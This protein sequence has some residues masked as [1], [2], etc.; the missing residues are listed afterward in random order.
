MDTI[1][2][3]TKQERMNFLTDREQEINFTISVLQK[4]KHK[5]ID[6]DDREVKLMDQIIKTDEINKEYSK[7]NLYLYKFAYLFLVEKGLYFIEFNNTDIDNFINELK[8]QNEK[9][10]IEYKNLK[11]Q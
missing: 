6:I 10:A 9:N 3:A 8:L 2:N 11:F 1:I 5:I 7:E 4:I